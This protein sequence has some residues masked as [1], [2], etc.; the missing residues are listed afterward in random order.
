VF[1][2]IRLGQ[3][4]ALQGGKASKF[5]GWRSDCSR[6]AGSAASRGRWDQGLTAAEMKRCHWVKP[7][8]KIAIIDY[9]K[10]LNGD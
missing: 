7:A 2:S 3:R 9:G 4:C 10:I 5:R 6:Y 1:W 8:T